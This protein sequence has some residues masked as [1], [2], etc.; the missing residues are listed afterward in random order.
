[1][2]EVEIYDAS[3]RKLGYGPISATGA[4]VTRRLDGAG[5]ISFE[6]PGTDARLWEAAADGNPLLQEERRARLYT[7]Q[8]GQ[9][10]EIGRGIITELNA[11]DTTS[12]WRASASGVDELEELKR[13]VCHIGTEFNYVPMSSVAMTL[14]GLA[15]WAAS[16]DSAAAG[17]LISARFD[18]ESVL[19]AF[20]Q[21]VGQNGL[22]LRPGTAAQTLEIGAFGTASGLTLLQTSE[23]LPGTEASQAVAAIES[24]SLK[25]SS[26]AVANRIFV[27]G[28]GQN[29]DAALTL[30]RSSRSTPYTIKNTVRNGRTLYYLEDEASSARYGVIEKYVVIK[31]IAPLDNTDTLI[32][33]AADALYDAAAAW[34]QRNAWAQDSYSVTVRDCKQRLRAGD[35][36]RVIYRGFIEQKHEG[37]TIILPPR[38]INAVFWVLSARESV[39]Q[40]GVNVN[41]EISN[42]DRYM[43]DVAEVIVGSLEQIRVQGMR[44]QPTFCLSPYGPYQRSID[45]THPVNVPLTIRETVFTLDYCILQVKTG[46]FRV[47]AKPETS[48]TAHDHLVLR[49]SDGTAAGTMA[50]RRFTILEQDTGTLFHFDASSD[51]GASARFFETAP[52]GAHSHNLD[53]GIYD[54]TSKPAGLTVQVDGVT[55]ASGLDAGGAGLNWEMNIA[56]Q[57]NQNLRSEHTITITC[58]SGQG[59]V[60]VSFELWPTVTPF[61]KQ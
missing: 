24:L 47:N 7:L 3:G 45:A 27:F 41:L 46:A 18:G 16:V 38:D 8:G 29:L 42:I 37:R 30:A 12:A 1:M 57:L 33:R 35:T 26:Q 10:V 4:D 51:V 53:Y 55:V 52:G 14:A 60:E 49:S 34:L 20:Q 13:S 6:A 32:A 44:V 19:K 50:T 22:H 28:A 39:G 58:A 36:V 23:M 25:R 48:S 56:P 61:K 43:Q 40:G 17:L 5:G 21:L 11:S 9:R 2:I 31:E 54:D 59:E 15:G